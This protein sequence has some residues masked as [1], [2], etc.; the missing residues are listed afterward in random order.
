MTD[1]KGRRARVTGEVVRVLLDH[2]RSCYS[3]AWAGKQRLWVEGKDTWVEI[4]ETE[5]AEAHA[6]WQE[7]AEW[8]R[9]ALAEFFVASPGDATKGGT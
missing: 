5:R 4:P 7:A 3:M 1:E 8:V 6:R 2:E 9:R